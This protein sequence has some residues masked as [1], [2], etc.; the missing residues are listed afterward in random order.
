[1]RPQPSIFAGA[2]LEA[3]R[4]L[5]RRAICGIGV[6]REHDGDRQV[7]QRAQAVNQVVRFEPFERAD[8]ERQCVATT[9]HLSAHR[10]GSGGSGGGT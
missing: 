10:I 4:T 7:E 3:Q 1:M 9:E 6:R 2:P 8:A 5:E